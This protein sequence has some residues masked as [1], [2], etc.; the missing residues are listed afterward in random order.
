MA[1]Y[2]LERLRPLEMMVAEMV[3][4]DIPFNNY[5]T[6][7]TAF[8]HKAGIH[9]KAVLNTPETYEMLDPHDFGLTRYISIAHRLTGWNAV[10]ARAEQLDL[11]L[12]DDQ[13]KALTQHIKT[14]AD[15]R[16]LTLDDVDGLLRHWANG[17]DTVESPLPAGVA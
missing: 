1:K 8:T 16:A 10:K 14:L 13:V 3:G 15:E 2:R 5:I 6:G 17:N 7:F 9:A 11:K 12:S 4:V